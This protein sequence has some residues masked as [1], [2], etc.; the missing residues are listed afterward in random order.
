MKF[1][2]LW[3]SFSSGNLGVGALSLSNMLLID[4][5]AR[6]KGIEPEFLI[7]GSSGPCDYPPAADRF[8][9]EFI[10]FNEKSLLKNPVGLFQAIKSCDAIFD[11]GEGDSFSDIYGSKRLIKLL[12]SKGMALAA[13][14]PLILSPQTIGPFKSDTNAKAAAWAMRK[15]T[16]VFAR[17]HQSFAVLE[18]LGIT[19]RD[20]VI[21]VAFHLPFERKIEPRDPS[22]LAVGISVSALL[23]HGGYEGTANQFGLKA[24]YKALTDA[25][26]S[27]LLAEGHEVHLV[28]HVIPLGFPA[29]DDYAVSRS[30]QE[31]YPALKVAPRFRGP[32]EAKSYV[33]GM[34]F[35]IGARMHA[36]I[37][38]FSAGVPVV[39]LAY[40]RKFAGLYE[41]LDYHRVVDLKA[42]TTE[43]ALAK[44]F[45]HMA[46]RGQL[47][48]EV[49]ASAEII[50]RKLAAY[51][52]SL[53]SLMT[54]L[55]QG[56]PVLQ[57]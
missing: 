43:G 7:I 26:I 52:Y 30:L 41:S 6:R 51:S 53:E 39:P 44:V 33:S 8:K 56:Q 42:E 12:L 49:A 10:E 1:G 29:E 19:N 38:A 25:L 5:A 18:Q 27:R 13:R 16:L 24:D 46:E 20:E 35:F 32:I 9:Y 37:A 17:D 15:S 22:R 4:E 14:V 54:S 48:A 40:S 21:D 47:K 57:D 28:P 50:K 23:H 36:T 55:R 45:A 2:L 3:H 11:I 31:R 34:D